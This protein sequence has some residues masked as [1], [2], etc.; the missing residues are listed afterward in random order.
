MRKTPLADTQQHCQRQHRQQGI[1]AVEH[2]TV[3]W[4]QLAAIF[5]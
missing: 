3:S 1:D 5:N 4:Q 2:A